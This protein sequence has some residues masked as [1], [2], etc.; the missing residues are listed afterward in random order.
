MPRSRVRCMLSFSCARAPSRNPWLAGSMQGSALKR[1]PVLHTC[2][3]SS[4][5]LRSSQ[6]PASEFA[7]SDYAIWPAWAAL[8]CLSFIAY[9]ALSAAYSK[10]PMVSA[11]RG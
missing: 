11:S 4:D 5:F 7:K 8:G 2:V 10:V 6:I 1:C 9:N 3:G